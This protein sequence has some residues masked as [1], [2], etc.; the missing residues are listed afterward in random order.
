M[1]NVFRTPTPSAAAVG[2]IYKGNFRIGV[3][4][5][6]DFGPTSATSYWNGI[7]PVSGG[8][9]I[10]QQAGVSGPSIITAAND[11]QLLTILQ[12]LGATGS[13]LSNALNWAITQNTLVVA[14]VDYPDIITSGLTFLVDSAFVSSY[15][16]QNQT[17][18]NL[19][20]TKNNPNITAGGSYVSGVANGGV[21]SVPSATPG[22][23][24]TSVSVTGATQHTYCA[25]VYI[26]SS[27]STNISSQSPSIIGTRTGGNFSAGG[28][29]IWLSGTTK[30][31]A[32]I[33]FNGTTVGSA[34]GYYN[35]W[36]YFVG[37]QDATTQRFYVDGVLV[38]T[39]GGTMSANHPFVNICCV[40][41]AASNVAALGGVSAA[42]FHIYN[43]ALSAA[44][45]SR[46]Y[47]SLRARY[48]F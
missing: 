46:N 29:S 38:T 12:R 14:N 15:P 18:Y 36:R 21:I 11:S 13:T 26:S 41:T 43:R 8:Y 16:R 47:N 17:W 27:I 22:I 20:F 4:P 10:Y 31:N 19:A 28:P 39:S 44:E 1:G 32:N 45:I 23:T 25:Y 42:T 37:T 7:T 5:T 9:T 2:D 48:G 6:V 34:S 40:T 24:A 35:S 30:A 33:G 3:D